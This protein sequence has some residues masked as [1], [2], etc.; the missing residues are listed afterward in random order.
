[1]KKLV[2]AL[3]AIIAVMTFTGKTSAMGIFQ[4]DVSYIPMPSINIGFT[5]TD[6]L[7]V[8]TTVVHGS[9]DGKDYISGYDGLILN[10]IP[11]KNITSIAFTA[12]THTP[13]ALMEKLDNNPLKAII[14]LNSNKSLTILVDGS[15][16]CFGKT[17]YGFV[18]I[19]LGMIDRIDSVKL[20]P[21]E[22][23]H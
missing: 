1:M 4:S 19:K 5:V 21:A 7:G 13:P 12:T 8:M 20:I 3:A 22:K 23:A 15:L 9:I 18:R 10:V 6:N 14:H 17:P 16:I 2:C 11:L